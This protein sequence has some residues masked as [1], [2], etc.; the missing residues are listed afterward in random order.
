MRTKMNQD[1]LRTQ[2]KM[3]QAGLNE[4]LDGPKIR[5]MM[6]RMMMMN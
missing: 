6:R 4:I 3:N 2:M 1:G 5:Q